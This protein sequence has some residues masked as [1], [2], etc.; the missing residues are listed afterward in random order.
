MKSRKVC[1]WTG[2]KSYYYSDAI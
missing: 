1:G 2:Y